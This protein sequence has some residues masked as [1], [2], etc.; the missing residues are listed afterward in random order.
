M[1][2]LVRQRVYGIGGAEIA[3]R[4]HA[5]IMRLEALWSVYRPDSEISTLGRDA[6]RSAINVHDDTMAILAQAKQW[7]A[8]TDGTFD[9]T[10]A[11]LMQLWRRAAQSGEAPPADELAAVRELVDVHALELG[12]GRSARLAREGQAV[13][14]GG[15][16]K[17]YAADRCVEL[18]HEH[19][20]KHAFL[21]LGGSLAAV[22]GR[23]DGRPWRVGIQRPG[24]PRGEWFGYVEVSDCSV[25]TSGSYE[26]GFDIAGRHYS[27]VLDPRTGSPVENEVLSATIISSSSAL[28]DAIATAC[29]VLGTARGLR[30]ASALRADAVLL[31]ATG[32]HCTPDI[33]SR[34]FPAE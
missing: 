9:I 8:L 18:Y 30:L 32:V 14:L 13:D 7:H 4:A 2:T 6:G 19:G 15:V 26:R 16:G 28:A 24:R 20:A 33:A 22:G 12:P 21:D 17:G 10:I 27:H 34:F 11:P 29:L 23:P 1:G 5:E 3:A 31:D 25:V